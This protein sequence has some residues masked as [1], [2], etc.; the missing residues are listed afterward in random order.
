M[1]IGD[2]SEATEATPLV[3]RMFGNSE[4]GLQGTVNLLQRAKTRIRTQPNV[5]ADTALDIVIH[6]VEDEERR[7]HRF[8]FFS[9]FCLMTHVIGG[10]LVLHFLEGWSLWDS[11]YFCVVTTTTVGYGDLTPTTPWAKVFVIYYV[12]VSSGIISTL[13]AY[14]VGLLLD[15]QE[16]LLMAAVMKVRDMDEIGSLEEEEMGGSRER[17]ELLQA[18]QGLNLS[19]YYG[20]A[21]SSCLLLSVIGIG[22]VVFSYMEQLSTLDAIYATVIS[23]TTVGFGDFEPTSDVTKLIMTLWL[24][25]S[26]ICVAKVIADFTDATSKAK[27]RAVSRRL[28]TASMDRGSFHHMDK[29]RNG[30]LDRVDFLTEMLVNGGK[31]DPKEIKNIMLRFAVL[32]KNGDGVIEGKEC[33]CT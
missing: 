6:D 14:L 10:A 15:R 28:L 8:L 16:E 9:V 27:Q 11:G 33:S 12:V 29:N 20:L 31:V 2:I 13:L 7:S 30:R 5:S 18:T 19:D 25:I 3:G 32:D 23:A 24:C 22:V 21:Y 4:H 1:S 17:Q 26:T